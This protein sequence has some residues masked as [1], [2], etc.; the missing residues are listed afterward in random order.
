MRGWLTMLLL[1]AIVALS[2][3]TAVSAAEP[4]R[5]VASFSIL[6][7]MVGEI[8]GDRVKVITLVGADGD[9]HVYQPTPADAKAM[10]TADLIVVN[11]LGFESWFDRLKAAAEA[12]APVVVASAGVRTQVMEEEGHGR[13]TDPHAWQ[14]LANGRIYVANI[15]NALAAVRPD[16]AALFRANAAAYAQRLAD[17][18]GWVRGELNSIPR[19]E[20]KIITSHDAFGYFGHAYGLDLIAPVG[21]STEA[22]PTAKGI[23]ALIRQ[24]KS[25]NVKAVFFENMVDPRLVEQ[26]AHDGGGVVGGTLYADALSSP[27]GPAATYEAMFRHNVAALKRA[28]AP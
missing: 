7:D 25:R 3:A 11:G 24:M 13:I 5:V 22:E 1:S 9:A 8:G 26:I 4:V 28:L 17:L 12:S 16:D 14:D 27:Q 20:R 21:L 19:S 10:R 15:A 6:G 23:A 2:A 18:E